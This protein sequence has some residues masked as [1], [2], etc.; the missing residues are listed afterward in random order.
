MRGHNPPVGF[1]DSLLD[2]R[3]QRP[4]PRVTTPL[5]R[6]SPRS[7][8]SRCAC[9]RRAASLRLGLVCGPLCV[10]S[11]A[12]APVHPRCSRRLR[13]QTCHAARPPQRGTAHRCAKN[14]AP[15]AAS[16][17]FSSPRFAVP[18][19]SGAS[20]LRLVTLCLLA[21]RGFPSSRAGL[22]AALRPSARPRSG[23][24]ALFAT[25]PRSAIAY[26]PALSFCNVFSLLLRVCWVPDP[27]RRALKP[28]WLPLRP[29]LR[30]G[31]GGRFRFVSFFHAPLCHQ[32][33]PTFVRRKRTVFFLTH[34]F[35]RDAALQ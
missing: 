16:P 7:G 26:I 19:L 4:V 11:L 25:A 29:P 30:R 2:T 5:L 32:S 15:P 27:C 1:A 21:T 22:R 8:L 17:V 35:L 12:L 31:L 20:A 33:R 14:A 13:A 3:V 6:T 10:P 9:S 18:L 28:N 24:S 23:P 34:T